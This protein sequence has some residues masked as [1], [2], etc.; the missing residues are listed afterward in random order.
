MGRYVRQNTPVVITNFQDRYAEKEDWTREG[1]SV[2]HRVV[3]HVAVSVP[4]WVS[5]EFAVRSGRA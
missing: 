5:T 4:S 3:D 1:Q 2:S